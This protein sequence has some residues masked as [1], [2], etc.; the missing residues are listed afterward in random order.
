MRPICPIRPI[1]V[2]WERRLA[3]PR[4]KG[5]EQR[6]RIAIR[7]YGCFA[8]V[9]HAGYLSIDSNFCQARAVEI[10]TVAEGRARLW[11]A[12]TRSDL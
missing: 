12:V 4:A 5:M 6:R 8:F 10:V 3:I 2:P 11:R 7:R 1:P 9:P